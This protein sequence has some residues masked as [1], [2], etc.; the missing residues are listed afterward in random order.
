LQTGWSSFFANVVFWVLV[1]GAKFAFDWFA[2]MKPL[3][4]PIIALW[5]F[6]WLKNG[7]NW[8]DADFILVGARC[9]PSF[10]VM[11]NDTQV[12]VGVFDSG[13]SGSVCLSGV[14]VPVCPCSCALSRV[15]ALL[16]AQTSMSLDTSRILATADLLLLCHGAVWC[17]QGH[18]TA[19]PGRCVNLPGGSRAVLPSTVGRRCVEQFFQRS[20]L[21]K[22]KEWNTFEGHLGQR[23]SSFWA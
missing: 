18:C 1:L 10:I 11:M 20:F 13:S 6:D 4:D 21:G 2:L 16:V 7:N 8:G 14:C 9:A 15:A 12:G 5:H 3:E 17:H 22:W 23:G 19:Q